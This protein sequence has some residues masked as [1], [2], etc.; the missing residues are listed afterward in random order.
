MSLIKATATQAVFLFSHYTFSL[1]LLKLILPLLLLL[2]YQSRKG[3]A[4]RKIVNVFN[5]WLSGF[6]DW[7]FMSH[8]LVFSV[9]FLRLSI[10]RSN[11]RAV[12]SIRKETI[13]KFGRSDSQPSLLE[14][15]GLGNIG[16]RLHATNWI[17][18]QNSCSSDFS[19]RLEGACLVHP[20][21]KPA[22]QDWKPDFYPVTPRP[23]S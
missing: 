23:L 11:F 17:F 7:L 12:R 19:L 16:P 15:G 21:W 4:T 3:F 18:W 5:C 10:A 20:G 2:L 22:L 8:I 9:S 14:P 1:F 6:Q 13:T